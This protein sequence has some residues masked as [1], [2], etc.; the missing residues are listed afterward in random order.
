[1]ALVVRVLYVYGWYAGTVIAAG[2]V[3]VLATWLVHSAL[4][5]RRKR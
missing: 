3:L 5:L 1:V 2:F 4:R